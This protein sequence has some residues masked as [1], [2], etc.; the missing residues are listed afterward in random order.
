MR[1]RSLYATTG[2]LSALTAVVTGCGALDPGEQPA[3][4]Q[5]YSARH[6]DLEG[7][8][9][10]FTDETGISVEF[11]SG[12]DAELLERLKAEGDDTPADVFMTVDAGNLWNAARQDEL[13]AISSPALD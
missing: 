7:A 2:I 6:Y 9:G 8:F 1:R 3:D 13:A 12:D 5:I 4:L 10:Q 11:L